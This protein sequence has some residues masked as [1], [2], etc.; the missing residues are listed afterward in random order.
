MNYYSAI[1]GLRAIAVISV[2]LYHLDFSIISG[3]YVG[4]DIFFVISGFLITQSIRED[5]KKQNFS[6]YNFY[7]KRIRRIVPAL[8]FV[9]LITTIFSFFIL[10]INELIEFSK[11]VFS[12]SS[13]S[14]NIFF[15]RHLDYFSAASELKP[16]LHTW[17]LGIEEQFYIIFPVFM[18]VTSN[19]KEKLIIF[20]I[21]IILILSFLISVSPLGIEHPGANFFLPVTRFWELLVGSLLAFLI[22]YSIDKNKILNNFISIFGLIL[23]ISSIVFLTKNSVFPG[24]N[25]LATVF[26]TAL[27]I[28]TSNGGSSFLS[29]V[30]SNK[31][32]RYI[33]LIS[34]SLYL[35]HWPIIALSKNSIFGGFDI[36]V[37]CLILVI[38][39]ILSVFTYMFVEQ[40]FRTRQSFKRFLKI[41]NGILAL[42]S[43]SII[44]ASILLY[45]HKTE[46]IKIFGS[47]GI[48]TSCFKKNETLEST[49][50]CSFGD[51]DSKKIFLLFGDSHA[52][53]LYP[54]F[55]KIAFQNGWRGISA[56]FSG[57][58]SLFGVYRED[59]IGNAKNCT[60]VYS[61]NVKT[62]IIENKKNI[63]M[64]FLVSR[65]RLYEK[66]WIKNGRLQD[67][68][69]F[70][71]DTE[72]NSK[73]AIDSSKVLRK[74]FIG[75]VN[76]ISEEL[77]IMT[78]IL[79]SVP[80]LP[81]H[82]NKFKERN[83]L[84]KDYINQR[85]FIDKIF[86]IVD[87]KP[88]VNVLDPINI[89]CK[90]SVCNVYY[91]NK[92]LYSDDNHVSREG[93]LYLSPLLQ[94][95][96]DKWEAK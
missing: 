75:T 47:Q 22:R 69:H 83:I 67:A 54:A 96:F 88:L 35:W 24:V 7:I 55:K 3:G 66:G 48:G 8:F 33:G 20:W 82:I 87:N 25:A 1:D 21:I 70:L 92:P 52:M 57:C 19:V 27:I 6:I 79:V 15:W 42:I 34:Y 45:I 74:S 29:V 59:G 31:Y 73:N 94:E 26:G 84:K 17:S 30:L 44:S 41:K 68:T 28:F 43:L 46:H 9:V 61:E 56:T 16:L 53:A 38:I 62:F 40:P 2:I 18:L 78:N 50:K 64:I 32:I 89:L 49:M 85:Q 95:A 39:F 12:V 58:P 60:G 4:V 37:K 51:K 23:V 90:T 11:S 86:Y 76:K 13:F 14:S 81:V 36:T 77:S 80:T 5:I 91:K 10:P 65:W 93:A 63:D 71:S 72:N